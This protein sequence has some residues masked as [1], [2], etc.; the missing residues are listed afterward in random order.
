MTQQYY[1]NSGF[2][3]MQYVKNNTPFK[4]TG[5]P[6]YIADL[7]SFLLSKESYWIQGANITIDGGETL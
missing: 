5:E 6:E 3:Y 7:I 1:K 4:E 2:D